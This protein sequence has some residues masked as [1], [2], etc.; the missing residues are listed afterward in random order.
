MKAAM[1]V[2]YKYPQFSED[3]TKNIDK[4]TNGIRCIF[5]E[6]AKIRSELQACNSVGLDIL[7]ELFVDT[8]IGNDTAGE[9]DS[10][11]TKRIRDGR[12][13]IECK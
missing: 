11:A 7:L 4:S 6:C 9:T 13:P 8:K 10:S 2:E 1:V 3:I 5:V 12:S